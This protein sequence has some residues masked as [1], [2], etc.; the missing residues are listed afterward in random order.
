[1]P[2]RRHLAAPNRRARRPGPTAG[3]AKLPSAERRRRRLGGPVDVGVRYGDEGQQRGGVLQLLARLLREARRPHGRLGQRYAAVWSRARYR[4]GRLLRLRGRGPFRVQLR[5][6]E[7][8]VRILPE[9]PARNLGAAAEPERPGAR[10]QDRRSVLFDELAA[11]LLLPRG[12][13]RE[14]RQR[15]GVELRPRRRGL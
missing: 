4:P 11:R 10:G 8:G 1:P 7:D 15:A 12:V 14:G 6:D 9:W 13:R 5:S 2:P 3:D